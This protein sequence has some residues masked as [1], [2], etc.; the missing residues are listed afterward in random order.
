M[1]AAYR[2]HIHSVD[3]KTVMG[4]TAAPWIDGIYKI[5][6]PDTP[7]ADVKWQVVVESFTTTQ[8]TEGYIVYADSISQ[9]ASFST[10]T[11]CATTA[12]LMGSDPDYRRAVEW[13]SVGM[14]L[15]N[16]AFLNSTILRVR[17]AGLD[18]VSAP[19]A[20]DPEDPVVWTLSLVVI[21]VPN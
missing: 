3:A 11:Q 5:D 8:A 7:A 12:I 19:T 15:N 14:P 13:N 18:G 4:A 9:A 16:Y 1:P 20:L 21:P 17:L 2:L 10:S 6:C